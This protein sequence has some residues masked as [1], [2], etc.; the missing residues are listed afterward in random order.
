MSIK[1]R[2]AAIAPLFLAS[3]L[4]AQPATLPA[5]SAAPMPSIAATVDGQP[6]YEVAVERELQELPPDVHAKARPE[7]VEFLIGNA[8]V[9]RYLAALKIT[10]DAKEI[11]QEL[12]NIKVEI[13]K[14]GYEY[15]TMLKQRRMSE[16]EF[17]EH[18]ANQLRWDKF[19]NQQTNDQKLKALYDQTPDGFNGATVHA[20]HILLPV[21]NDQ[22]SREETAAK[23]RAIKAQIE[24]DVAAE[25]AK[26]PPDTDNVTREKR[27]QALLDSGFSDA[28]RK[29]STCPSK[30]EGGDL[31]YFPRFTRMAEPLAQG[32]FSTRPFEISDVIATR[33]GY[34]LVLIV[35]RKAGAP[36]K[37]EDPRV[38]E[39]V[40][41]VYEGKLRD[42]V[43]EQMRPRVKVEIM[44]TPAR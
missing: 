17:K 43:I 31:H 3:A 8:I 6:I 2:A 41:E 23:L 20:R 35:D 9:D 18:L 13:K 14:H 16:A 32:A 44:P 39:L 34:H 22:K 5:P 11:E 12:N 42:A 7:I 24:R 28:A 30:A 19:V 26:L 33:F 37:F 27:K 29:F 1:I 36:T 38:K 10:V 25:L 15:A 21:G 4:F 40:K